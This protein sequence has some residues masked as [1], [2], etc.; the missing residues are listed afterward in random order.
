MHLNLSLS[1]LVFFNLQLDFDY[2][3]GR[4]YTEL[5]KNIGDG[6]LGH[7]NN[8]SSGRFEVSYWGLSSFF[9]SMIKLVLLRVFSNF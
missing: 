6:N 4:N 3:L 1:P 9:D 5:F 8:Y 7:Y 2:K